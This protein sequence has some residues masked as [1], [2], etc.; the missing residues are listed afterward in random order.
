MKYFEKIAEEDWKEINYTPK[1]EKGSNYRVDMRKAPKNSVYANMLDISN[2]RTGYNI[3]ER[4]HAKERS[5]NVA[6]TGLFATVGGMAG[7]AAGLIKKKPSKIL[8]GAG[9]L[10]GITGGAVISNKVHKKEKEKINKKPVRMFYTAGSLGAGYVDP[11]MRES[12]KKALLKSKKASGT[13]I[14]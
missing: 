9:A 4:A 7:A 6:R 8:A 12:L 10:A 1:K 13:F 2:T 5:A 14:K 11:D 3:K